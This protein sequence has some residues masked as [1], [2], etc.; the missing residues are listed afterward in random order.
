MKKRIEILA[1]TTIKKF[2]R[3]SCNVFTSCLQQIFDM[4]KYRKEKKKLYQ[5]VRENRKE[6]MQMD[7]VEL[8]AAMVM[9]GEQKRLMR[10]LEEKGEEEFDMCLEIQMF[11]F[12]YTYKL[13]SYPNLFYHTPKLWECK[14]L[15]GLDFLYH[16]IPQKS[17]KEPS[18]FFHFGETFASFS[19]SN[20]ANAFLSCSVVT[21]R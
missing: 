9:M 1:Q 14:P 13:L 3:Q 4:L 12:L 15:K 7:R 21:S 18:G 17:T 19:H 11:G 10:I 8:T 2:T 5:Y 20:V 16:F 6:L